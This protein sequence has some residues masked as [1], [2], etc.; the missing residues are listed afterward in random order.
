MAG[1]WQCRECHAP[2]PDHAYL[3]LPHPLNGRRAMC[4]PC[5]DKHM[6]EYHARAV[7]DFVSRYV[8]EQQE[9]S[10]LKQLQ[11]RVRQLEALLDERTDPN[12]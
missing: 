5:V 2:A 10:P 11:E 3:I 4:V 1:G 7:A 8:K 9:V 12:R 6:R